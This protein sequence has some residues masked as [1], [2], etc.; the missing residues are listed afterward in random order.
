MSAY[1]SV[2]ECV[3][4]CVHI[5][6]SEC[7][8]AYVCMCTWVCVYMCAWMHVCICVAKEKEEKIFRV[9][10]SHRQKHSKREMKE[11]LADLQGCCVS[12]RS[13]SY[14]THHHLL[15]TC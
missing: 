5:C 8:S 3:R 7:V 6:M 13:D 2:Y 15:G 10:G 14:H 11:R 9:G 4:E 1:V 12:C